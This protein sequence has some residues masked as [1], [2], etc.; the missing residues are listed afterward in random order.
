MGKQ[1][2]RLN[3]TLGQV[4]YVTVGRVTPAELF[5]RLDAP[6]SDGQILGEIICAMFW[7]GQVL[8][9]L[10][11]VEKLTA[12][13]WKLAVEIMAYRRSPLWSEAQFQVIALWC[14]DRF[15]LTQWNDEP[16]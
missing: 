12:A 5:E 3:E 13:N 2:G 10:Q 4:R 14:R 16:D 8:F 11:R 7:G 9:D 6:G 15:A 1:H